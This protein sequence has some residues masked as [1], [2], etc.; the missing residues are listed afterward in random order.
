MTKDFIRYDLQVLSALKGV[1]RKILTDATRDG[2]PGEHHFYISFNTNAPGVRMSQRLREKYP[3]DMTVVLQHQFWD[4]AVTE[5][6]FEVG[7]SFN[8][9]PERLLVPFEAMTGFYDP[10]V[11]FGLKFE[12]EPSAQ[13]AEMGDYVQM[14]SAESEPQQNDGSRPKRGAVPAIVPSGKSRV[15][16]ALKS[17]EPA[18]IAPA[19]AR[20]SKDKDA[21]EAKPSKVADTS[22]KAASDEPATN[23]ATVVSLDSFRKKI[24][25]TSGTE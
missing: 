6:T 14:T 19:A 16:A 1:I 22:E 23:G 4:L 20:K 10:S 13:S 18:S 8:G 5:H 3:D 2:L 21:K 7:L 9:I 17:E 11:Q 15:P 25:K 24:D 12:A